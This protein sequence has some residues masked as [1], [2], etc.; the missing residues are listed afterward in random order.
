MKFIFAGGKGGVGKTTIASTIAIHYAK[1]G[2]KTLVISTDPAHSLA[3]CLDQEIGSEI[4]PVREIENLWALEIDSEKATQEYGNLLVQQGFEESNLFSQFFGGDDLSS[5]SPPGADET[6]AFLKLLEFMENPMD[7]DVIV[8][9]TAPTGHTLKLLSLP[10]L[11]S[12]WLYKMILLR[13]RL[14][15]T[16]GSFKKI[17][18][19]GKSDSGEFKETIET[20]RK[21]IESARK[22]LQNSDITEFIPIT[23]PTLMSIWETERLLQA[24]KQY[25]IKTSSIIV[26][27]VNPENIECDY[28]KLKNKQHLEIIKQLNELYQDE[29]L[30]HSIEMSKEE[31]RGIKKLIEFSPNILPIFN[32]KK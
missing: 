27:Q 15:S 24:L 14:S 22:Q 10:E 6:V 4:V 7:Y 30:I 3:D 25:G 29:Y 1:N 5:L 12:N 26:N 9:D 17:F 8:Y 31:I 21:R 16:L 19:G 2:E 23:I 13:K 28:C 11:T 32:I 18:G 20:L